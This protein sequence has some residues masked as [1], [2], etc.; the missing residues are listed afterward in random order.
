[1]AGG[2]WTSQNKKI[3]GV[4]INTI[5]KG[6]SAPSVGD[7]GV[8]AIAKSLNWGAPGVIQEYIPGQDTTPLIGYDITSDK[9]LFLREMCKGSDVTNGPIKILLYRFTGT[10][11]VKASATVGALT[12]TAKYAGTRGNDITIVIAA[13]ADDPTKYDIETVVDGAVVHTQ[14]LDDLDNLVSNS[15]VDFT[16]TGTTI[17]TTAGTA[18]TGGV[19]GTFALSD[20]SAFL[21]ALEPYTFDIVC[22]DIVDASITTAL[23]S[24]VERV[25]QNIGKKCQAVVAGATGV[26]SEWVINV[27]NGVKLADGTALTNANATWWVA[28]AEAGARYNQSLTYA[29]YPG[30]VAANPKLTNDQ[31]VAAV[32]AGQIAFI[33]DFDLVKICTDINTLTTYTPTKGA[34][35]AKNRVMRVLNQICND[36]YEHFSLY[37]IGKVDN[38]DSGR[39]LMKGWI[40]G[41]L[42]EMEANNGIQ[43]FEP[44]DV[45]VVQGNAIDSV[46]I[47]IAIM[48][49]DSV[50]KIYCSITVSITA[51]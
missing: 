38:N 41:Y 24:F 49:V 16:G 26:N 9:A 45:T 13:N 25:S 40:V 7:K 35:F 11:F 8:V 12:A 31:V 39:A 43:N 51:A 15:W 2:T 3:P 47:N 17:T 37:F 4:Y 23:A 22:N 21:T 28:G 36:V 50:E 18:L 6:T 48:P 32:E 29:Q 30:A 1:M 34:E 44:D 5:S 10:G 20:Y 27:N 33:D 14:T 46:L 42:K 19:D